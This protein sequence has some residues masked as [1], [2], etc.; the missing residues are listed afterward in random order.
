M[1]KINELHQLKNFMYKNILDFSEAFSQIKEIEFENNIDNSTNNGFC[2]ISDTEIEE[3]IIFLQ[4]TDD[5]FD[6]Y[7]G[8]LEEIVDKSTNWRTY[9]QK[10]KETVVATATIAK[11]VKSLCDTPMID[12]YGEVTTSYTIALKEAKEF[13]YKI[14][15]AQ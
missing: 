5:I 7:L 12:E 1:T 6:T 13:I 4:H 8:M 9:T 11:T 14:S 15:E 10:E 3:I 2:N